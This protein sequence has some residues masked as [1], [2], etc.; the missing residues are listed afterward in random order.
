MKLILDH[1]YLTDCFPIDKTVIATRIP[2]KKVVGT[3][4]EN[5]LDSLPPDLRRLIH[6]IKPDS[7]QDAASTLDWA[8]SRKKY[9]PK[10]ATRSIYL[11]GFH[12]IILRAEDH[13]DNLS[14]LFHEKAWEYQPSVSCR[15]LEKIANSRNYDV[16]IDPLVEEKYGSGIVAFTP[17]ISYA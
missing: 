16:R 2:L 12:G 15:E 9:N 3:C 4:R 1:C 7:K 11:N 10:V 6:H 5:N 13:A 8:G 17:V 14:D